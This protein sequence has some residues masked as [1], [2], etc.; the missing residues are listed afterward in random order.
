[1][2]ASAGRAVVESID[3]ASGER[4]ETYELFS[5]A[6]IDAALD[7]GVD[8]F[9]PW[10]LSSR[11]EGAALISG[12]A[13]ELRA[14][15][16]ELVRIV[17]REMGKP[18]TEAEAEVEKCAWA[19]DYYAENGN[20]FLAPEPIETDDGRRVAVHKRPLGVVLAIMPWN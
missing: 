20:A 12:V 6:Q 2:S 18:I 3:P 14:A 5:E 8:A 7:S 1:M 9:K 19:A 11:D 13:R 16:D 17:S 15:T 4:F 10:R